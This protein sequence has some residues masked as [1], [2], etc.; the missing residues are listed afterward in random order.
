LVGDGEFIEIFCNASL[1]VCEQRD[2][3]GLYKKAR[4]GLI[5]E[6][7]GISSVYEQP[8]HPE[9]ELDTAGMTVEDCVRDIVAYL[10][11]NGVLKKAGT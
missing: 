4:A 5:P 8:E 2:V 7:T 3:K 6:F 11:G 1:A 9:L 10:E